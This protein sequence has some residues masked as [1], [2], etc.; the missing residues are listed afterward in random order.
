[1]FLKC[2]KILLLKLVLYSYKNLWLI[3]VLTLILLGHSVY[4][5]FVN[6]Q[7][8]LVQLQGAKSIIIYVLNKHIQYPIYINID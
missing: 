2:I 6:N 7:H 5:I 8:A 1:M 4:L 3:K